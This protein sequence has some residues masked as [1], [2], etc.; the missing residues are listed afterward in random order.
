MLLPEKMLDRRHVILLKAISVLAIFANIQVI[1]KRVLK[2]DMGLDPYVITMILFVA[3]SSYFIVDFF[4]FKGRKYLWF[5]VLYVLGELIIDKKSGKY[6]RFVDS[7][8]PPSTGESSYSKKEEAYRNRKIDYTAI[9]RRKEEE[10][11]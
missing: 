4:L 6:R 9:A 5:A 2:L 7:D 11:G 3:I 10:R 1:S 8:F